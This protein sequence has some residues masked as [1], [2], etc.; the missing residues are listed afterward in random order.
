MEA[1]GLVQFGWTKLQANCTLVS[2]DEVR[3]NVSSKSE[4]M[5]SSKHVKRDCC[6]SITVDADR[7]VRILLIGR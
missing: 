4:V 6:G 7:L 5:R 1:G 3:R 2:D